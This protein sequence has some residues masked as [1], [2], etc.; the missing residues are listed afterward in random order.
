MRATGNSGNKQAA[1]PV[2]F[3]NPGRFARPATAKHANGSPIHER[4]V[5]TNWRVETASPS[6]ASSPQSG[7]CASHSESRGLINEGRRPIPAD[8][9]GPIFQKNYFFFLAAFFFVPFFLAAFFFAIQNHLLEGSSRWR[10]E[11]LI[12]VEK[13]LVAAAR[14]AAWSA[15]IAKLPECLAWPHTIT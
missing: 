6:R 15:R 1:R 5:A 10:R 8:V 2:I 3:T 11:Q 9:P 12:A 14:Y 4:A 13:F 7:A